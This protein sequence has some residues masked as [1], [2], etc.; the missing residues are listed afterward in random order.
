M[1]APQHLRQYVFPIQAQVARIAHE[2]GMPFLLH[3]CGNLELVMDDV[4]D[5]VGIDVKHSFEDVIEPVE[6]FAARYADRGVKLWAVSWDHPQM[7][8]RIGPYFE[9]AGFTFPCLL[10]ADKKVGRGLGV[11]NLP[12]TF[13]IAPDGSIAWT[14]VGYADGDEHEL[15]RALDEVLAQAEAR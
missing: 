5:D 13:L 3:A 15:A 12:T 6:S 10:D 1:I 9:S 7:L 8:D 2:A 14:H 11:A 4:I